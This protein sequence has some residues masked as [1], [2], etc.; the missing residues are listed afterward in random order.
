MENLTSL[1]YAAGK[2]DIFTYD[3]NDFLDSEFKDALKINLN[4]LKTSIENE[5]IQE[6]FKSHKNFQNAVK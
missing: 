1:E 2:W 6:V 3:E 4:S 5:T